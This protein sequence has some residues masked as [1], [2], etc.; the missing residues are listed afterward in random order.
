MAYQGRKTLLLV[1]RASRTPPNW[2][3]GDHSGA[4]YPLLT[5]VLPDLDAST[6]VVHVVEVVVAYLVVSGVEVSV[7][8]ADGRFTGRR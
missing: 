2:K 3:F 5:Q 1:S 6:T 4:G 7:L 8:S